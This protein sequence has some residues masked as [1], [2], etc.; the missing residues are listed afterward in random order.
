MRASRF[1]TVCFIYS[2]VVLL[3]TQAVLFPS[4]STAALAANASVAVCILATGV[5]RLYSGSEAGNPERYGAL[6]YG[7][8]ALSLIVTAIFVAGVA[9]R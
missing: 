6:A 3:A 2:G 9:I 8:A 5:Y 1:V 7:M 4:A